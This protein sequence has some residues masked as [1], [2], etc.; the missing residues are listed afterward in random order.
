MNIM[1]IRMAD[2]GDI[3]EILDLLSEVLEIHAKLRP[4]FFIG[5]KTKYT[6]GELFEMMGDNAR[7]IYV[8]E[9]DGSVAGYIFCEIKDNPPT[10]NTYGGKELYIDDLCVDE[11]FRGKGIAESLLEFVKNEAVSNKFTCITLNVWHG[12]V[13]AER[14]Y[15]KMGFFPRKTMLGMKLDN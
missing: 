2:Q 8:A 4:D 13:R 6:Y 10:N 14:F 15:E 1:N 5:G 11:K 12:N 3:K 7:P 9:V